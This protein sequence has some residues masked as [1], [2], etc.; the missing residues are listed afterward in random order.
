MHERGL[1]FDVG[2]WELLL[3]ATVALIVAGPEKLPGL[4]RDATRWAG[5]ARRFVMQTKYEIEQQLRFDEE[6]DLA[7]KMADLDKIMD[8]APDKHNDVK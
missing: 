5:K 7:T 1:M 6:K 3:I 8:I 2:F 4:V